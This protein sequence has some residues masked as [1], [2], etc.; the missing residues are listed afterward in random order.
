MANI[1]ETKLRIKQI[2]EDNNIPSAMKAEIIERVVQDSGFSEQEIKDTNISTEGVSTAERSFIGLAPN[3]ASKDA[4]I[5]KLYPEAVSTKQFGQGDNFVIQDKDTGQYSYFNKPGFDIGD[6]SAFIP[7]PAAATVASIGG[8]IKGAPNPYKM[9]AG[10]GLGVLAAE[11][12]SDRAFQLGGGEIVRTPKEYGIKRLYDF[13][14]GGLSEVGGPALLKAGKA[15]FTGV[16]K[17]TK[18][19]ITKN[20]DIFAKANVQPASITLTKPSFIGRE[21]FGTLESLYANLPFSRERLFG[22]G[23]NLQKEMGKSLLNTVN[24]ILPKDAKFLPPNLDNFIKE[25]ID[26]SVMRFKTKSTKYYNDAFDLIGSKLGLQQ[27]SVPNL[28]NILET[29]AKPSGA[30][31]TKVATKKDVKI[32][33]ELGE[34]VEEGQKIFVDD[35]NRPVTTLATNKAKKNSVLQSPGLVK[36]RTEILDNIDEGS[37]SFE[38]LKEIRSLIGNKISSK[39]LLD[40]F[41][42]GELKR[43]YGALSEDLQSIAK[44][45]GPEAFKAMAAANRFYKFG[46]NKIENVL[47][48]IRNVD[49]GKVIKFL[50]DANKLDAQYIFGLKQALKPDEFAL[51]QKNII[52]ELGKVPTKQR[53]LEE[54][55][56][57]TFSSEA[58]LNNWASLNKQAKKTLFSSPY[59]KGLS[60]DLDYLANVSN[61]IRESG[62]K[63]L[64]GGPTDKSS[65]GTLALLGGLGTLGAVTGLQNVLLTGIG[66]YGGARAL[67]DPKVVKWLV[68][69]T[70]IAADNKPDLY[71][72][73]LVKAGTIFAGHNPEVIQFIV[74]LG[75]N[76]EENNN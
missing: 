49:N 3:Q 33:A 6:I 27:Q 17:A 4:T 1:I 25:G 50:Q 56:E 57:E 42:Q 69:G 8:A 60:D 38:R 23:R 5:K 29:L 48:K 76:L 19:R 32:L 74:N 24:K 16:S 15:V 66:A 70:K 53:G 45:A 14:L 35:L 28:I 26:N 39:S 20:L 12:A 51:V 47:D 30:R 36:L 64:K 62:V 43:I 55:I 34:I 21:L 31:K 10:A 63:S 52:E 61:A 9:F 37:L 67:S 40:D 44:G 13:G 72:K 41:S 65:V 75:K 7:R 22:V 2:I 68:Q 46:A 71:F 11:E 59:Y 18:D 54:G 73:H 58:F